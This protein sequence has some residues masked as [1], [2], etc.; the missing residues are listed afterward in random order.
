[1]KLK[2]TMFRFPV[3]VFLFIVFLVF[4][5]FTSSCF[6]KKKGPSYKAKTKE[7]LDKE[8]VIIDK[9]EYVKVYNPKASERGNQP[10]YLYVPVDEYLSKKDAFTPSTV[11]KEE[12]KKESPVAPTSGT[13]PTPSVEQVNLVSPPASAT[14]NLKKKVMIAY[15]DD[16]TTDIDEKF[17]DWVTEKLVKEVSRK[18]ARILFVDYQLVKEFLEK[19]EIPLTDLSKPEVLR[20]LNE[21]FGVHALVVG[22]LS[23]P[24]VFTTKAEKDKEEMA[25]AIIKI[26]MKLVDALTGRTLKNLSANNP[27]FATKEKGTFSEEKAKV[28]AIDL[29]IADLGRSLAKEIEGLDWFC[30]IARVDGED[31]YLNAG[32]LTGLKVGDVMEVFPPGDSGKQGGV[33]GKVQISTFFGIDASMGKLINGKIPDVDDILKMPGGKGT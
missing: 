33:K 4:A 20:L 9:E 27:N 5:C 12:R 1:M 19:R 30:R 8:V 18:S 2:A 21:A 17:G 25:S 32:K 11:L 7:L 14:L 13:P 26:E 31:V 16:R 23:G 22:Q 3:C 28:K 29:T 15:F 10:K 24:Y 6:L